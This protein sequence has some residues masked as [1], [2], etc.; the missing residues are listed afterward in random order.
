[1]RVPAPLPEPT[2]ARSPSLYKLLSV[3]VT[4]QILVSVGV[5][6]S[7]LR[8]DSMSGMVLVVGV[9]EGGFFGG[10]SLLASAAYLFDEVMVFRSEWSVLCC[11]VLV[12]L[13]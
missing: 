2:T 13:V 10:L 4:L 12:V 5:V 7:F 3:L 8:T 6:G 1:M 11:D 9:E